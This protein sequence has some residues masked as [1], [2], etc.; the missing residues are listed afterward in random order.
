MFRLTRSLTYPIGVDVGHDSVKMIQLER[1][2]DSLTV[3]AAARAPL[4]PEARTDAKAR[5]PAAVEIIRQMLRRHSFRGRRIVTA[6]PREFLHVRHLRIAPLPPA[7]LN[8]A[9]RAEAAKLLP[10]DA[11][12]QLQFLPAGEVRQGGE[13]R[14]E[15]IVLAARPGD[16]ESYLR[17]LARAGIEPAALDVEPC[18]AFRTIER[19]VRRRDDELDVH[20]MVD[21]GHQ[22][23]QV[24]I[25]RGHDLSF[26]KLI[27]VGGRHFQE[28]VS[29]KLGIT[30]DEA[31]ALRR[32]LTDPVESVLPSSARDPVRNAANDAARGTMEQLAREIALCLRYHAVTFRGQR[33]AR[34]KIIGGEA[35]DSQ[36][37]AILNRVLMI[38]VDVA[39]PLHS[40]DTSRMSPINRR[41]SLAEWGMAFGLALKC[42]QGPFGPRDG[43]PRDPVVPPIEQPAGSDAA[44]QL[45]LAATPA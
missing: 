15:M 39:R 33:P 30:Q 37:Q 2:G 8:A 29:R 28:A 20:V 31:Q 21:V 32:R 14:H 27:D 16:V 5:L 36:L 1:R 18:A 26:I 7:Q 38:Q 23:S 13:L 42:I 44:A 43:R 11:A 4:P 34:V 24:V 17:S 45:A 40:V 12:G 9:V 35:A 10:F 3:L 25:G 6:L 41:G 22:G 19:F